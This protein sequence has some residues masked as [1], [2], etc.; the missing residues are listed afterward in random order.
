MP[1]LSSFNIELSKNHA[2]LHNDRSLIPDYIYSDFS[3]KN[4]CDF[5]AD[6]AWDRYLRLREESI[7]NYTKRTGQKIQTKEEKFRWSAVVNLNKN[8]TLQDIKNLADMFYHKFGWQTI[9]IAIHKDEGHFEN[10]VWCPNL[11][12]HIEFFM[13]DKDGI[14]RFKKRDFGKKTMSLI[15][16]MVAD[17]LDMKRGINY[18]KHNLDVAQKISSG[19]YNDKKLTLIPKPVRKNHKVQREIAKKEQ[20]LRDAYNK[21]LQALKDEQNALLKKLKDEHDE[22]LNVFLSELN[23]Y[24]KFIRNHIKGEAIDENF[25][26]GA[27]ILTGEFTLLQD[28]KIY[29]KGKDNRCVTFRDLDQLRVYID[30]V[31]SLTF[32][33]EIELLESKIKNNNET[34]EKLKH[35]TDEKDKKIKSLSHEIDAINDKFID[36]IDKKDSKIS[37][38]ENEINVLNKKLDSLEVKEEP[39]E[40]LTDNSYSFGIKF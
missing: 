10:G 39:K 23:L 6:F 37:D 7:L 34:I 16:D 38:L 21:K 30:K 13:L 12:A 18:Y 4:E 29:C 40:E 32:K 26:N 5:S 2:F 17:S 31:K 36:K 22:S 3:D 24:K 35:M 1:N 15:Q 9:Q 33:N 25:K 20:A 19:D 8:H 27:V 11:H 28:Y 14:Y